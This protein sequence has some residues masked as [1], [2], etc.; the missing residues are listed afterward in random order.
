MEATSKIYDRSEKQRA[1]TLKNDE[2]SF[3][4]RIR[5]ERLKQCLE[6]EKV[7]ESE[8][9]MQESKSSKNSRAAEEKKKISRWV[10]RL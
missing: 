8:R 1:T 9:K 3:R 6:S 2:S 5:M 10:V 4:K 7:Q